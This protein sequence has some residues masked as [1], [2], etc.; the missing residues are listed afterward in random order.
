MAHRVKCLEC[1][2]YFDRDIIECR[3]IGNRYAHKICPNQFHANP[4]LV[5]IEQEKTQ[6][7]TYI[8]KLYGKKY[9]YMTINNQAESYIEDYG[10]TWSGMAGTLHWFYDILKKPFDKN[11]G[12]GII[13]YVYEQAKEYYTT[14]AEAERANKEIIELGTPIIFNIQS[15]RAWQRPPQLLNF[16]D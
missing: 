16:E 5:K 4:E 1:G 15:P 6:F 10:Y 2:E 8:K 13:P 7:Y 12:I 11:K 9:N 14:I 3:K